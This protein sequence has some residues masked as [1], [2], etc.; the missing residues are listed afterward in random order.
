MSKYTSPASEFEMKKGVQKQQNSWAV[1]IL[2]KW[3]TWVSLHCWYNRSAQIPFTFPCESSH[4]GWRVWTIVLRWFILRKD[5]VHLRRDFSGIFYSWGMELS[6]QL[7]F[8]KLVFG[9]YGFRPVEGWQ[10]DAS[11]VWVKKVGQKSSEKKR[12]QEVFG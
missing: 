1:D 4:S 11:V 6:V 10:I 5:R 3:L 2:L 9:V 12:P 7:P 8:Q